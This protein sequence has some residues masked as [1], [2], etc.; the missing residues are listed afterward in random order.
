MT[1]EYYDRPTSV[2]GAD[3]CSPG[4]SPNGPFSL[5][6]GG[7]LT[8]TQSLKSY[9]D[10]LAAR[11]K[12]PSCDPDAQGSVVCANLKGGTSPPGPSGEHAAAERA[13]VACASAASNRNPTQGQRQCWQQER[14]GQPNGGHSDSVRVATHPE[15][16]GGGGSQRSYGVR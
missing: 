12:C 7:D 3:A 14:Q 15:R 6:G 5:A 9:K 8:P 10:C 11:Q 1:R 13:A 16:G 2:T 4:L